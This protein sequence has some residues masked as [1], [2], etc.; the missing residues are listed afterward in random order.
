M[1]GFFGFLILAAIAYGAWW[2]WD[3][4]NKE[5]QRLKEAYEAALRD[6]RKTKSTDS[7]IKALDAGRAY[8]A[9]VRERYDESAGLFDEV[10]LQNDL[11]AYG[12]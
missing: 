3:Q 9:F 12:S 4:K 11:T 2:I 7:R 1:E 6:L 5:E 10:Q 8:A